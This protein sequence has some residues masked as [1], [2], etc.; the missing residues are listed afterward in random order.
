LLIDERGGKFA[1][2]EQAQGAPARSAS[3][4]RL[5]TVDGT[6]V[7]LADHDEARATIGYGDPKGGSTRKRQAYTEDQAGAAL[8]AVE[9]DRSAHGQV[10]F[11][12]RGDA[13]SDLTGHTS[14]SC[15]FVPG[16]PA[17]HH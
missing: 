13:S 15:R 1:V 7:G 2:I 3:G 11:A 6:A 4:H 12:V 5:D 17:A 10:E 16:A 8:S 14:R 9:A